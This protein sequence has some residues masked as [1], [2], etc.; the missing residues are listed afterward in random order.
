MQTSLFWASGWSKMS[1]LVWTRGSQNVFPFKLSYL[2]L[3]DWTDEHQLD[4]S[5]GI[6]SKK[7]I[8]A[9][10]LRLVPSKQP[11]TADALSMPRSLN[12][13]SSLLFKFKFSTFIELNTF[14]VSAVSGV[15]CLVRLVLDL[16]SRI[17]SK[18]CS[19]ESRCLL[20]WLTI[21]SASDWPTDEPVKVF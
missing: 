16:L 1:W 15:C 9:R 21:L 12:K 2:I 10:D 11:W 14:R 18:S 4:L 7:I 6:H 5:K 13:R 3:L 17:L 19:A 20:S 8:H